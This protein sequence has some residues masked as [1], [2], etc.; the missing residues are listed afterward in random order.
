MENM[1][2]NPAVRAR[3]KQEAR[4]ADD[5]ALANG[6]VSREELSK[7]N[8]FFLS[9]DLS[10][11]SIVRKGDV[12]MAPRDHF[13]KNATPPAVVPP[14]RRPLVA[15]LTIIGILFIASIALSGI[16]DALGI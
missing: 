9:L 3:R 4:E 13:L 6:T 12:Q 16:L 1:S 14:K 5:R 2:F 15:F 8:G 11:S 10:G 7:R